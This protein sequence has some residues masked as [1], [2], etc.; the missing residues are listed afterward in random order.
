[1]LENRV[2]KNEPI[3]EDKENKN[4]KEQNQNKKENILELNKNKDGKNIN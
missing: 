4:Q 1:M 3:N 2:F